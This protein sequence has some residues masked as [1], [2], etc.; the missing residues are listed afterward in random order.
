MHA[1][2][3][4][5]KVASGMERV[6]GDDHVVIV[7]REILRGRI[8]FDVEQAIADLLARG[9]LAAAVIEKNV[10]N[11]GEFVSGSSAGEER[12]E[13]GRG[14]AGASAN[15]ENAKRRGAT[16]ANHGF[17]SGA[18]DGREIGGDGSAFVNIFGILKAAAG[19]KCFEGAFASGEDGK[20]IG[21][22]GDGVVEKNAI[23]GEDGRGGIENGL[24]RFESER[25]VGRGEYW[26]GGT[27][28]LEQIFGDEFGE[29][30]ADEA[31]VG[32]LKIRLG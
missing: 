1:G 18:S 25:R 14:A 8:F 9:K 7:E 2:H 21:A 23:A 13:L 17:E 19:E 5:A 31:R 20:K 15:F 29:P 12:D 16:R 32:F 11:V 30:A 24:G 6:G 3:G 26:I 22:A 27:G 4:G 28:F 10:G